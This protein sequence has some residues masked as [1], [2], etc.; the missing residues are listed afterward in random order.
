MF[1]SIISVVI[2][3]LVTPLVWPKLRGK[4][5]IPATGPAILVGNHLG[6][7]EPLL[8]VGYFPHHLTFPVKEGF[9]RTD[10][11]WHR[12][13]GWFMRAIHQVPMDRAG[14]TAASSALG[15]MAEVLEAGGFVAVFPE[16]HRSPDGRLYRGHTGVARLALG[17]DA[18]IVPVAAFRTRFA[19]GWLPFPWLYRPELRYGVPF[20]LDE[21]LRRAYLEAPDREAAGQ[22][23]R[24]ATDQIMG[25]IQ[26]LTGQETVDAYSYI[27]ASKR[28]TPPAAVESG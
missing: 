12:L 28:A 19:R 16:G 24:Q 4:E 22:A 8:L 17:A 13:V 6:V 27:P 3:I 18:P 10:T 14:G 26:A 11:L 15:S 7:G 23:L 1:Y 9:F 25:Q 2:K 5:N 20:R 21:D